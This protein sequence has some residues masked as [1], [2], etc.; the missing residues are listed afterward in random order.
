VEAVYPLGKGLL[1]P[2]LHFGLRWTIEG[3]EHIPRAGP[4]LLASN[5]VSYL[6]PFTIAYV[7]DRRRRRIRFL[8]KSE[9]FE[10]RGLGPLLRNARQIPVAR[11]T[12]D[13]STS[14]GD[15]VQ[16]LAAGECVVVF[17]EGTISLDLEPMA[18]KTGTVR[19]A[20]ASGVPVTP[21]GVWGTH[22]MLFKGR[23]PDWRWGVAQ[24][25]VVGAPLPV[26]PGE[27][28][29]AA[30]DRLMAAIAACVARAR[31]VYPQRPGAG[32][33]DWWWREPGTAVVRP[34]AGTEGGGPTGGHGGGLPVGEVPGGEALGAEALG[35]EALGAEAPD[36][37]EARG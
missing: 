1:K 14:L 23:K 33:D 26:P 20:Q 10:K 21:M 12:N 25:A 28:V 16:A 18:G 17:P 13:A 36:G 27:D 8:A 2:G 24:T 4:V 29:L 3:A 11:G 31:E 30:T 37:T 22:R 32:E 34:A 6:D 9:L 5:H 15:A 35:A 19:L 7:A